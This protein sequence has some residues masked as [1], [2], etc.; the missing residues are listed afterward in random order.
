[1][2]TVLIL[3]VLNQNWVVFRQ[4]VE[5]GF[6]GR[7]N[8]LVDGCYSF[9]QVIIEHKSVG[10]Y[11]FIFS[12]NKTNTWELLKGGVFPLI[13]RLRLIIEEQLGMEGSTETD[14]SSFE[15]KGKEISQLFSFLSVIVRLFFVM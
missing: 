6:Q 8:K 15:Q 7:T 13:Q 2:L 11:I 10:L 14:R 5:G 12:Y 1:M 3:C 4:G 9:W